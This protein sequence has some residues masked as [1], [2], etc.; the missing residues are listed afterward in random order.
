MA[1]DC[2]SSLLVDSKQRAAF[3]RRLVGW[4][5]ERARDLAWRKT[6]DPYRIW[7]SE[8]MLQQTTVAMAAPYFER[9]TAA[10]P[11][12]QDLAAASEQT[13]LRMWEGLG[14]YRRARNLH[15][16]AKRVAAEYGGSFPSDIAAL[17]KLPGIGRYTAGAI[18][19]F[20]FDVPAPIV[21]TNTQ[22]VLTRLIAYR[23]D[24]ASTEGQRLIWNAAEALVPRQGAGR[25]NY[26]LMELGAIVCKP[27]LPLCDQCPVQGHCAAFQSGLQNELPRLAPRVKPTPV[28]EAAVVVRR[29]GHVLLRQRSKGER[30]ESMWDFPRFELASE[31]PLFVRDELIAKVREQTGVRIEPGCLLKTIKH[32]VTRF[33][34]T[35]D[36]YE[37]QPAGGRVRCTRERPVRWTPIA[38]L[39]ALPLSVSGRKIADAVCLTQWRKAARKE[40]KKTRRRSPLITR[41]DANQQAITCGPHGKQEKP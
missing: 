17:M 33:R 12:V 13:I 26:A 22:R 41:M 15:A 34:I 25:F 6:R 24:P 40:E 35:L 38:E 32:G 39:P 3:R 8:I 21:E 11:T 7:L 30:W 14:Y 19:S 16:A 36:C 10:F 29:N 20:A 1:T 37:A 18:A 4:Y 27:A 9:F 28:R 2:S 5:R 31:G 23:G